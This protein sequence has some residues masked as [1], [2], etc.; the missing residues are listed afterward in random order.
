MCIL[1]VGG[2]GKPSIDIFILGKKIFGAWIEAQLGSMLGTGELLVGSWTGANAEKRVSGL[3]LLPSRQDSVIWASVF[4]SVKRGGWEAE[5]KTPH[6]HCK[7][8]PRS[9]GVFPQL[10]MEAPWGL[11][12][13]F[14]SKTVSVMA[15]I[16]EKPKRRQWPPA[17][18][19]YCLYA[20]F[21]FIPPRLFLGR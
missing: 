7:L 6:K 1:E 10:R 5:M 13:I 19:F 17:Q 12:F 4:S 3:K 8:S 20:E 2:G 18:D 11:P 9:W 21:F 15:A 14:I 16:W